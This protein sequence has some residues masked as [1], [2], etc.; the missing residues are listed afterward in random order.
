MLNIRMRKGRARKV[1]LNRAQ[2]PGD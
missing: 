1:T 2:I